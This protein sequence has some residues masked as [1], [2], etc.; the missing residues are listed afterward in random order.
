MTRTVRRGTV[1]VHDIS[2]ETLKNV[3]RRG[4]F[5]TSGVSACALLGSSTVRYALGRYPLTGLLS[6]LQLTARPT[7][8]CRATAAQLEP[9][10][11]KSG[12]I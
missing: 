4:S 8:Y 6:D 12:A 9:G 7:D 11:T 1:P 3:S 2:Q 10:H 5:P